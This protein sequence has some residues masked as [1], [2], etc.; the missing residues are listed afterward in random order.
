MIRS[1]VIGCALLCAG[2]AGVSDSVT[3]FMGGKD[4]TEPPSPLVEFQSKLNVIE[5]WSASVGGG[6]AE[7]Y[8]KLVPA[9]SKQRLYVADSD[10][11]VE[12]L[13]ATNGARL[14]STDVD[15]RITGGPGVGENAVLV[16]TGE[17]GVIALDSE[18]GRR[19]WRATVSS[20]VLSQPLKSEGIVIVRT[21]DG[22]VFAL[23]G[24]KG[25]QLW[26]YDRTVPALTL[27]GTS[28]PVIVRG[29]VIAGFDAGRLAALD[30]RTGRLLWE[31]SVATARGRSE[32]ERMVDIDSDPLVVNDVIYVTTF[33]GQL[34]AVQLD[35][36][37]ILWSRD[38]SSYAGFTADESYIY[39]TDD[40]ST[41]WT[42]DRYSGATLWR[43]ELLHARA[44]TGPASIGNFT[45]VGDLEGYLHWMHKSDGSFV[46][47]TRLSSRRIIVQPL[48]AG[49]VLYAYA[50]DGQLA[51]YTFR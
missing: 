22:K 47:R 48:V 27:R 44:A 38:I 50:T 12:A 34:A 4:N 32:L 35:G 45:V 8:L 26:I 5:L 36:G 37:R 33:Q 23:D 13:D 19:L 31:V 46:A 7:Q 2:C 9:L 15:E 20:E 29:V 42:F 28:S 24:A 39:L 40:N 6:T 14:W 3:R 25:T 21:N 18:T 1:V 30:L 43:Q 17:G 49:K 11:R 10:G 51:A 16:G 41:V